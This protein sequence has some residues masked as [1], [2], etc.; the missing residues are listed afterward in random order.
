MTRSEIPDMGNICRLSRIED[1][2]SKVGKNVEPKDLLL[3]MN[4]CVGV[5]GV[6]DK[7]DFV[8]VKYLS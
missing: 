4:R 6:S 3:R 2:E 1:V 7:W 5:V 8:W